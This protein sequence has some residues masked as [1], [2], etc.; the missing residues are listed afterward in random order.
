MQPTQRGM[1]GSLILSCRISHAHAAENGEKIRTCELACKWFDWFS[2]MH[3]THAK[4]VADQGHMETAGARLLG[5]AC[6]RFRPGCRARRATPWLLPRPELASAAH[7]LGSSGQSDAEHMPAAARPDA[8]WDGRDTAGRC[9][10]SCSIRRERD[11]G[12]AKTGVGERKKERGLPAHGDRRRRDEHG[13]GGTL[14]TGS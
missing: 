2:S 1:C 12:S 13:T 4:T 7:R 3:R 6:D 10:H 14:G 11:Q 9:R 8:T 5:L